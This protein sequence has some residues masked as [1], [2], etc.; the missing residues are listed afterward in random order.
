MLKGDL[1]VEDSRRQYQ[2]S[3]AKLAGDWF[4]V[5]KIYVHVSF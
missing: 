3:F 4:V 1:E 2:S 5:V